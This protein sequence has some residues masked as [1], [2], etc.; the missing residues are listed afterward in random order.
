MLHI[1]KELNMVICI[2][3]FIYLF[4]FISIAAHLKSVWVAYIIKH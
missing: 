2:I 3:L 4:D 1:S